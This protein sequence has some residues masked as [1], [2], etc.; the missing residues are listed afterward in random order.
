MF[1]YINILFATK[2]G[3]NIDVQKIYYSLLTKSSSSLRCFTLFSFCMWTVY[4]QWRPGCMS[5]MRFQRLGG[6]LYWA[7]TRWYKRCSS[8]NHLNEIPQWIVLFIVVNKVLNV[9]RPVQTTYWASINFL[10]HFLTLI[11]SIHVK[12]SISTKSGIILTHKWYPIHALKLKAFILTILHIFSSP[13]VTNPL[14]SFLIGDTSFC[15]GA[16]S[17]GL[18]SS[19]PQH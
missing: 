1:V 5:R 19:Y 15:F 8:N 7:L 4:F 18:S 6:K 14:V 12:T 16:F 9:S 13:V 2:I 10:R 17:K 11:T 3:H